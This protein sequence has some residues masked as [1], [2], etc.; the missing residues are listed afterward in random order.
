MSTGYLTIAAERV[1]LAAKAAGYW[2]LTKPR[3]AIME[4]IVVAA[5]CFIGSAAIPSAWLLANTLLGTAL[6]AASA[7]AFNQWLER[8]LD[9]QMPRTAT[10][11]LPAGVL[12]SGEALAF[13]SITLIAGALLLIVNV[14]LLA[15]AM[16]LATWLLYVVIYTPLKTRTS[17]NTAVGAVAGAL[18]ALIG[19]A[20]V[21]AAIGGDAVSLRLMTLFLV[22]YLWQFPHFMAIAW[23]YR[24]DYAAAG[25]KMLTVV[26]PT[27]RQAGLLA[28]R[29]AL[30]LLPLSY[31][32]FL[33]SAGGGMLG[34]N[35]GYLAAALVLAAAYLWLAIRF[36]RKPSDQSARAL[37]RGSLLYLPLWLGILLLA[38]SY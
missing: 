29:T 19:W 26:D 6:V 21:G 5:A 2:E 15:A 27:G 37:L 30:V 22:L 24:R 16:G 28:V 12:S 35:G 38:P 36:Y 1:G 17:A 9:A 11:P 34:I 7:S 3:I 13:G 10:R 8:D 32:P 14:N 25:M 20:A 33:Q 31:L 4:L 18:P 23:L